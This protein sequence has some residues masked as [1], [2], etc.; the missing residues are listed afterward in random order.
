[1]YNILLITAN[2][3]CYHSDHDYRTTIVSRILIKTN[4]TKLTAPTTA[5][6]LLSTIDTSPVLAAASDK[7]ENT[8]ILMTL[9]RN[10][11]TA[12]ATVNTV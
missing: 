12:A 7:N 10:I 3:V 8:F 5:Q 1:M 6:I 9:A 11:I 2:C 4:V